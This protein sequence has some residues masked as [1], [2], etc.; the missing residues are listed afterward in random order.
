MCRV[1]I[2]C[3]NREWR[4]RFATWNSRWIYNRFNSRLIAVAPRKLLS[5]NTN[6]SAFAVAV[7]SSRFLRASK[8]Y[9]YVAPSMSQIASL[10]QRRT[11]RVGLYIGMFARVIVARPTLDTF[12]P[13]SGFKKRLEPLMVSHPPSCLTRDTASSSSG[14]LSQSSACVRARERVCS[15]AHREATGTPGTPLTFWY[16]DRSYPFAIQRRWIRADVPRCA[17]LRATYRSQH[18]HGRLD[19]PRG[20]VVCKW[21]KVRVV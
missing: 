21:K 14:D 9:L 19:C 2:G 6:S 7:H 10:V 1:A 5:A 17:H 4:L 12:L 16:M 3:G 20:W 8:H 18:R 13:E 15:R 11:P